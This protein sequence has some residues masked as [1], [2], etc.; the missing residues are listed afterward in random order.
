MK[1]AEISH[2]STT[3]T[4]TVQT[5]RQPFFTKEGQGDF[6]ATSNAISTPFF[7]STTIQPKLKIGKPNDKYEVE[8]DAMADKVVQRLSNPTS[9]DRIASSS[10]P[11]VQAK[12]NHC[13]QEE[14]LQKKE[15]ELSETDT[16]LQQKSI[17]ESNGEQPDA[18]VQTKRLVRSIIQPSLTTEASEDEFQQKEDEVSE[19]DE[20]L[21]RVT[22]TDG[23]S[24]SDEEE[25]V[26]LKMGSDSLQK[27]EEAKSNEDEVRP[28]LMLKKTEEKPPEEEEP[29]QL[30]IISDGLQKQEDTN[31]EN[32]ADETASSELQSKLNASK[33][34]GSSLP[35][36]T[37]SSME[38]GFGA[39]FSGVKIHTG[40]QANNMNKELGARAF[41]HGSDIYFNKGEYNPS[42]SSGQHLLAHEL[43]HTVQQ[44]A[45]VRTKPKQSYHKTA[46]KV[47][48]VF[49]RLW[50]AARNV[51]RAAWSG[52]RRVGSAVV[53]TVSRGV[54]WILSKISPIL[55]RIPGYTLLTVILG[56]DI[57]TG[58]AVERNGPNLIKGFIG[59]I[60]GGHDLW[61]KLEESQMITNAFSWLESELSNLGLSWTSIKNAFTTAASSLSVGDVFSSIDAFNTKIKPIFAP[62]LAKILTLAKKVVKKVAEFVLEGFLRMAGPM[63][64]KVMEI[65]RKAGNTFWTIVGDPIAFLNNLIRAV[66]GGVFKF[67]NNIKNHLVGG[68]T[69]WLTGA[70]GDLPIQIPQ[71]F[72]VKGVLHL[73][74]Q[75]MG[76]TWDRIRQKLVKRVGEPLVKAAETGVTIVKTL[77]TQGPMG[78]W[79]MLKE[80]AGEI[81]QTIM[82]GIRNWV[83]TEL[84]KQGIIK[85]LSFLNPAGALVQAALAIYNGVMFF[86][87]N[88]QRIADFVNSI[89]SSMAKI[90]AG[91]ISAA[92]AFIEKA[93]AQ[94]IPVILS[95]VARLLNIGAIGR[96]IKKIIQKIRKPIDKVIRKAIDFIVKKVK[97]LFGR[98]KK[99]KD[100]NYTEKDRKDAKKA[101]PKVE[102]QMAKDGKV[103]DEEAK[104]TASSAKKKHPVIKS[105]TPVLKN[106]TYDYNVIFR[107]QDKVTTPLPAEEEDD[108]KV[109]VK[110]ND[111]V[112]AKYI[113]GMFKA[114]I[115]K[116]EKPKQTSKGLV[117]HEFSADNL[118]NKVVENDFPSFNKAWKAKEIIPYTGGEEMS[119]ED[120]IKVYNRFFDAA[121]VPGTLKG[122]NPDARRRKMRE[123]IISAA[124]GPDETR[125]NKETIDVILN[126]AAAINIDDVENTGGILSSL[127]G[128]IYEAWNRLSDNV[129]D[130][131]ADVFVDDEGRDRRA[132]ANEMRDK[133]NNERTGTEIEMKSHKDAGPSRSDKAQFRR[134]LDRIRSD[135]IKGLNYH[136]MNEDAKVKWKRDLIVPGNLS[137]KVKF[138]LKN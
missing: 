65:L 67:R 111:K 120:K 132:D 17:F 1:V 115:K 41:T 60:P 135:E 105:I 3:A 61:M 25:P 68:L 55:K 108:T 6:F 75:I 57:V 5:K 109:P 107:Q 130:E 101:I 45:A 59:L 82:G 98:G 37:R 62:I 50:N 34:S 113:K 26:Q 18:D 13:D 11:T 110:K 19:T 127:K 96:A 32:D 48:G 106:K 76:V 15:D 100:G 39:D 16:E 81:K 129:S 89:F 79:E 12:C 2:K 103:S 52:V 114:L 22:M 99:K 9:Q 30:K 56:K 8:A 54:D 66:K 28:K 33:G 24:P 137:G 4:N 91:N 58:N 53:E 117:K 131:H 23:G 51:G 42:T 134:Y 84:V 123:L 78:L 102:K 87:E 83:I 128:N 138:L 95:F 27:Q 73:G 70:M 47:Q 92:A 31:G 21:Q 125:S 90:A 124:K 35:D 63:G 7:R 74:L 104:K 122:S 126:R 36:D 10:T 44:G 64:A 40:S 49:G 29:V 38:S 133:E 46:P 119:D 77:I 88:W 20:E 85:I 69:N 80:K 136:F 118:K 116:V 121:N 112:K 72:D 94:G 86:V 97:K 71:N 14:K 93:M 43:T